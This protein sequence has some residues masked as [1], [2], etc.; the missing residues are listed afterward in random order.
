M[1]SPGGIL[2]ISYPIFR[3]RVPRPDQQLKIALKCG[4]LLWE[5]AVDNIADLINPEGKPETENRMDFIA[6]RAR[7]RS[8]S[9]EA[10]VESYVIDKGFGTETARAIIR[11]R[12]ECPEPAHPEERP[13]TW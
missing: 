10:R 4:R 13:L 11:H 6:R 3:E 8:A 1:S 12:Q 2:S 7:E 5:D 9:L